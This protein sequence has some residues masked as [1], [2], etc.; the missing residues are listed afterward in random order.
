MIKQKL[1]KHTKKNTK[2]NMKI[3]LVIPRYNLSNKTNY[4][5][6]FP[7]GLG[8]ISAV[9]KKA[10]YDVDCLN[11]NHLNGKTEELVFR[12]LNKK[13]YDIV[14]S[15]HTGIGYVVI[16]KILKAAKNHPSKPKT[17]VGGALITSEP[18]LMLKSLHPDFVVVGEGETTIIELLKCLEKKRNLS[19]INGIGY[20]K[21]KKPFFTKPKNKKPFFT[22]PRELIMDL[23]SLP[24]PDF[25]GFGYEEKLKNQSNSYFLYGEFDYP[26]SY[27]ILASRGCA[28]QCTFCYHSIGRKYRERQ[29][30]SVI[31]EL[32]IAIK[33]YKINAIEIYD[34]LFS[35]NKERV[36]EFCKK[37][38]KLIKNTPWKIK[39]TCQLV[40][41]GVDKKLLK[42][43]KDA[44]CTVVGFGFESYSEKVLKS[45]KK[46]ITPQQI[47]NVIKLSREVGIGIQGNFIFG[48]V[49]ETKE[50]AYKT[51]NYWK[52]ITKGI[53]YIPLDSS[54]RIGFIQPY[55]G[56][57]IYHH[58]IKKGI[59][60]D[61]LSFI[62]NKIAHT[63][64]INMTDKMTDNEI[65]KLKK[66]IVDARRKYARYVIPLKIKKTNKDRYRVKVKCPFCHEKI[67]YENCLIKNKFRYQFML[68]C[69]KCGMQFW[70]TSFLYKIEV[71]HY[72]KLDFLRR[73]Y[74]LIRDNLLKKRM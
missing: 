71:Y 31:K 52:K 68:P 21:N 74:L 30:D 37:I 69:R 49:A 11:L 15:G 61:K 14:C 53:G 5:Y 39:W 60:K 38:K 41:A 59:I 25:E 70:I 64:W 7:L 19:K 57:A 6:N 42:T 58:C 2:E 45:M 44:G 12:Q 50:T 8:Y 22:K 48:D 43:L 9:L 72:E 27:P 66:D 1:I 24:L 62:K 54:I 36:Y 16:E 33:K 35:V 29:I 20:I 40:V 32:E 46:P 67:Q 47:D 56:S 65:L 34:D 28:F 4:Q 18:E 73:N 13:K 26:R 55:P 63:N 51:L 10:K 3:L 23:D 17:I